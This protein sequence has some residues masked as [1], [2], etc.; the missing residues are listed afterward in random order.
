LLV[1]P[2]LR[3]ANNRRFVLWA[4]VT[5]IGE[6]RARTEREVKREQVERKR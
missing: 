1:A 3:N 5:E 2:L 4:K 6:R